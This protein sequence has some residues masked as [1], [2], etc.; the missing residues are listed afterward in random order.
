VQVPA[1]R[2]P[3]RGAC[4]PASW[5]RTWSNDDVDDDDG[6]A[7]AGRQL[8]S[9]SLCRYAALMTGFDFNDLVGRTSG[10]R[11]IERSIERDP[12]DSSM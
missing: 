10:A 9:W 3:V 1:G 5:I 11:V 6:S 8:A 12:I 7:R 4:R 2:L